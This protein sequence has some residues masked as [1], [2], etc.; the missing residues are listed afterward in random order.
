MSLVFHSDI[1]KERDVDA[2]G[3]QREVKVEISLAGVSLQTMW[4][5]LGSQPGARGDA[6]V[7][8]EERFAYRLKD[9]LERAGFVDA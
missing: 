6:L 5:R 9:R 2:K 1:I 4:V 8:A 3:L 7:E